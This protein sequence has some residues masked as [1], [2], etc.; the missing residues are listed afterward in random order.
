QVRVRRRQV[1]RAPEDLA[2]RVRR[3]DGLPLRAATAR[4]VLN[5]LPEQPDEQLRDI[6]DSGKT[7]TILELDPGWAQAIACSSTRFSPLKTVAN[8]SWWPVATAGA[9]SEM[10]ERLWRHSIALSIAARNLA[11]D[12]GDSDPGEVARASLLCR[13]GCWAV[14]SVDPEWVLRWWQ[15][16][17]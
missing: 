13:L 10:I 15:E 5:A 2:N 3:L 6:P 8:A 14:A 11:R 12:A 9:V 4:A 1:S 16:E 17:N 7:R